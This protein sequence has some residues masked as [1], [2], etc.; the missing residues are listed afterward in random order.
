MRAPV[1]NTRENS[2]VATPTI[3]HKPAVS[4]PGDR[5]EREADEIADR[6]MRMPPEP[7]RSAHAA[8]ERQCAN[9]DD[10]IKP[11]TQIWSALGPDAPASLDVGAAVHA[12]GHCGA[13][14]SQSAR[15]FFEP[16]FGRDLRQVR[17]HTD[18]GAMTGAVVARRLLRFLNGI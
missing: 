5:F 9:C 13:P 3:Q 12:V 6:V 8:I 10:E 15:D 14:L 18:S 17:V 4:S 7:A 11:P 16:R 1:P 2:A